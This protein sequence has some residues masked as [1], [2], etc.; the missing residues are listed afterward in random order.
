MKNMKKVVIV[1]LVLAVA[2]SVVLGAVACNQP[3][4]GDGMFVLEVRKYNGANSLGVVNT[5]GELLASKKIMVKEGHQ[6][7]SDA[8]AEA[9]TLE[10]G[11]NTI[12]FGKK[13]YLKFSSAWWLSDGSLSKE[14]NYV[15]EDY[16]YS[17]M[18]CD[19]VM[20]SGAT[21]DSVVG[22]KVYTIVIDGWDGEIGTTKPYAG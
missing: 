19:G 14:P 18:A 6:H 20:S 1:L 10:D 4:A 11:V 13:D 16:S 17:Y 15:A 7:V 9:A 22:V 3:T 2:A 8:L 21:A 5:D 12:S